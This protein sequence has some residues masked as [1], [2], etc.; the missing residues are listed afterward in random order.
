M[1]Q[2]LRRQLCARSFWDVSLKAC[3]GFELICP[4]SVHVLSP[5]APDSTG[6]GLNSLS[7]S[8]HTCEASTSGRESPGFS[9]TVESFKPGLLWC[10]TSCSIRAWSSTSRLDDGAKTSAT[11]EGFASKHRRRRQGKLSNYNGR[12]ETPGYKE[13]G[14]GRGTFLSV[15]NREAREYRRVGAISPGPFKVLHKEVRF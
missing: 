6:S 5:K 15:S 3:A 8:F 7:C 2:L 11:T 12:R 4:Q 14:G 9:R 1:M 13:R 10:G